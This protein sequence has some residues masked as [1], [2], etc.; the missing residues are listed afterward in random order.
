[1]LGQLPEFPDKSGGRHRLLE[2]SWRAALKVRRGTAAV[3][4]A[5]QGGKLLLADARK[6]VGRSCQAAF[7]Q[8]QLELGLVC[9]DEERVVS[10]GDQIVVPMAER[11]DETDRKVGVRRVHDATTTQPLFD[12]RARAVAD[13]ADVGRSERREIQEE[14]GLSLN[15]GI[16][17][18]G[19]T[20]RVVVPP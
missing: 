13:R 12:T 4:E 2:L 18:E 8:P 14:E 15:S 11:L 7:R 1:M 16:H 17:L 19:R 3:K 9:K 10:G 6:A 20:K 5:R